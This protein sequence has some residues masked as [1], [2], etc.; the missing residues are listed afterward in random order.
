MSAVNAANAQS[1]RMAEAAGLD[2][3]LF[4]DAISGGAVDSAY[5]HAKGALIVADE[6]PVSFAV[7]GVVKDLGL[8]REQAVGTD[9][10][11]GFIDAALGL[12]RATR[13][14]GGATRT[15][16]PWCTLSTP[17]MADPAGPIA[18]MTAGEWL[19]LL[20]AGFGAGVIGSTAGLASLIS[21]PALLLIGLPPVTANVT[22][23]VGLIG[24]SIGSVAGSRRELS[25]L[26]TGC[27]P[28]GCR[29]PSWAVRP[30]PRCCCCHRRVVSRRSCPTWSPRPAC[31]C[32]SVR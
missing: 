13:S 27:S 6:F 2:P 11:T 9:V 25:G 21:Y 17:R 5:A 8:I 32:C 28:A 3:Q 23:T 14:A 16:P 4:L 31:C 18:P 26:G 19:L 22:N 30:V 29:S 1:M 24:S 15:W 20:V 7:D 10:P 12:Y